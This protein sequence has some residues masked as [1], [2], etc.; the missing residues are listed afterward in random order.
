VEF[1]AVA[2]DEGVGVAILV[3]TGGEAEA[4]VEV[5]RA[6]EVADWKDW[7]DDGDRRF[8]HGR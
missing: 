1:V 3:T 7:D 2:I 5:N 4:M 8:G 6:R